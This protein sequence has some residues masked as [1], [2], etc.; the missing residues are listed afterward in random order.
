MGV[1]N[2]SDRRGS[3]PSRSTSI[4]DASFYNADESKWEQSV[5][6]FEKGRVE[7]GNKNA[8]G[9]RAQNIPHCPV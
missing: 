3:R 9:K 7:Y 1:T 4:L 5:I 8:V 2:S 6:Q